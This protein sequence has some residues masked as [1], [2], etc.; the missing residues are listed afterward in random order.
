MIDPKKVAARYLQATT[1]VW[2][3]YTNT[4]AHVT[5]K[6]DWSDSVEFNASSKAA[7]KKE[8]EKFC[9]ERGATQLKEVRT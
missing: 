1:A 9:R 2:E 4:K 7:F 5:F 3:R 6:G 8:L